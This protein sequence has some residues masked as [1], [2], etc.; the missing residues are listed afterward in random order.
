MLAVSLS[1]KRSQRGVAL[2]IALL[3]L[4]VV[5]LMGITAMKTSMFSAKIATGTQVDAMAF[6]GAESAV[7]DAFKSLEA[8]SSDDLQF[9]LS[10]GVMNRCLSSGSA[11]EGACGLSSRMD[12]RD[13]IKAGSR[14][15]QDGLQAVSGGQ[16]SMSGNSVIPMDFNFD[17]VGNAEVEEFNI[18]N[19]HVQQALKRGLVSTSDLMSSAQRE[20]GN[21]AE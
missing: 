4:V 1:F 21:E 14:M 3:I 12:S 19:H 10:G 11:I 9:F 13:L 17:I 16:V 6:E 18:D 7:S 20:R 5:S 15:R 2:L 8:M